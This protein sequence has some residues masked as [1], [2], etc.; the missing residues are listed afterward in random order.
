MMRRPSVDASL[1]NADAN[2]DD[3]IEPER[4]SREEQ[5]SRAT[6]EYLEPLERGDAGAAEIRLAGRSRRALVRRGSRRGTLP[7][8]CQ[9]PRRPRERRDRRRRGD[10]ADPAGKEQGRAR[11]DRAHPRPLRPLPRTTADTACGSAETLA[12]LVH[13]QGIEPHIPV[14]D[15]RA[16]AA[17]PLAA[18]TSSRGRLS[19]SRGQGAPPLSTTVSHQTQR[20]RR[21]RHDALP[22]EQDRCDACPLNPRCTLKEHGRAIMRSINEGARDLARS[23][24]KTDAFRRLPMCK[25]EGRDAVRAVEADPEARS[26][27]L[28][29]TER[30]PRRIPPCRHRPGLP[31]S[32]ASDWRISD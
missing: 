5:A 14:I 4:W 3:W 30:C 2:R 6:T 9:L 18:T 28:A 20:C 29:R 13:E 22:R 19:L 8:F 11:H 7:L 1:I 25:K 10:R 15:K 21:G 17:A 23:I 16:A 26:P 32:S 24:A 27:G 12:R 31:A